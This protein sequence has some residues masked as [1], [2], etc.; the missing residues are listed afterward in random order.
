VAEERGEVVGVQLVPR[1]RETAPPRFTVENDPALPVQI[2]A[3]GVAP[4]TLMC[5]SA[6]MRLPRSLLAPIAAVVIGVSEIVLVAA[7][8]GAGTPQVSQGTVQTQT[9]KILAAKTGQKPPKVS[10]PSGVAAKVGAAIRCTVIPY[11]MTQK[12]PATVTVRSIH[13]S[14]ANFYVQVGQALGQANR[15][16]F[17]ADNATI[18][19]A[20]S[21]APTSAAFISALQ[22]N[23]AVILD[24]QSTAPTKI[25][26]AA[27]T[28]TEATRQAIQSGAVAVFNT[29][30]VAKA[31][32]AIDKFCGQ[33]S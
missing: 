13:G 31:A 29:K 16:K 26:D 19:A 11:G 4:N 7:V 9:A 3:T 22:A 6:G 12:Y 20:L 33:S 8:A 15:Q 10:C 18:N 17:C 27:G 2:H 24:L 32:I 28:L 25:V 5:L 14:T 23:E 21:T 30:T 1:R